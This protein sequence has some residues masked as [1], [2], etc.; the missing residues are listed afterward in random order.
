MADI[1]QLVKKCQ[2]ELKM[3]PV[4]P[5]GQA[6]SLG[7]IG[8]LDGHAFRY[9]GTSNTLLGLPPGRAIP[10]QGRQ[11][12]EVTSGR[13]VALTVYAKGETSQTFGNLAKG[14]ARVEVTFGSD[15][16]FLL[17]GQK[18]NVRTLLEPSS[19]IAA[20]FRAYS[21][22]VWLEK[23]CFVFQVGIVGSYTAVMSHQSGA[24]L[25]LSAGASIGKGQI[26]LGDLVGGAHYESQS[27][28][29]EQIAGEKRFVAFFNAYRVKDGFFT[30]PRLQ[31]AG[32]LPF[33]ASAGQQRKALKLQG[34]PFVKA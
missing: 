3:R 29:L 17:G 11:R 9:V 26:S 22:G 6:M 2:R 31:V 23:Y 33:K 27:G 15:K 19:L 8:Y 12:V 4:L 32:N 18:L 13:E 20:M 16:S 10:G 5:L 28:A 14:K 21:A 7:S 34:N 1:D 25:L 24:K 30:G